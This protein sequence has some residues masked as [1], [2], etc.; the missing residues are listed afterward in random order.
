MTLGKMCLLAPVVAGFW[1]VLFLH[2]FQYCTLQRDM[3]LVVEVALNKIAMDSR[4]LPVGQIVDVAS[5]EKDLTAT[6]MD[7]T[8]TEPQNNL[9]VPTVQHSTCDRYA[10]HPLMCFLAF[11]NDS[12]PY[13]FPV[14]LNATVIVTFPVSLDPVLGL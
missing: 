8:G 13:H 11:E 3:V 9:D 2:F 1:F 7:R 6:A 4:D 14:N 5:I 12:Y 10:D